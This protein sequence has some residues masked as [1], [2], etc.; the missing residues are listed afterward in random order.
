MSTFCHT[1]AHAC[2]VTVDNPNKDGH[3]FLVIYLWGSSII[4]CCHD[5]TSH[6]WFSCHGEKLNPG[7]S[8]YSVQWKNRTASWNRCFPVLD[9]ALCVCVCVCVCVFVCVNSGA[10]HSTPLQTHS[11]GACNTVLITESGACRSCDCFACSSMSKWGR[12]CYR[13]RTC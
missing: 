12:T 8:F 5:V 1:R 13:K 9:L 4:P 10:N 11:V 3:V 6:S 2:F 7:L